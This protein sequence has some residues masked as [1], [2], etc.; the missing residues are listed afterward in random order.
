MT[1]LK[2]FFSNTEVDGRKGI[3]HKNNIIKRNIIIYMAL[4]GECTLSDLTKELHISV[5][6]ITKL[7]QELTD[8]DIVSDLGKV[9]TPGGRRPN[10]FGLATSAIYFVGVNI[11]RDNITFVVTDLQNNI[12]FEEQDNTFELID[13]AQ[14]LENIC[15]KIESFIER[16]DIERNKI[17]GIG[18]SITGRVN[19]EAGRSYKYFTSLDESVK[20]IIEKRIGIRVLF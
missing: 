4:H 15:N 2:D 18:V 20:D 19:P 9:E 10:V 8:E 5:P 17:L 14:C 7:V 13:R 1:S 16:S 11:D 6:T 3:Y 12:I